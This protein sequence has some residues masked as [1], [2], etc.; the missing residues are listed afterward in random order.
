MAHI[1]EIGK[2][3]TAVVIYDKSFNYVDYKFSYYGTTHYIHQFHDADGNVLVWKTTNVVEYLDVDHYE[4][5]PE[6]S[7][8]EMTF[9]VKEHG[10]YKE[11]DQTVVTRCKF[12]LVTRAKTAAEIKMEKAAEQLASIGEN[13]FVWEMPYSQYKKHYSDCETIINSYDPH[14]DSHGVPHGHPTIKVIIRE[15]R[16]KKSGVRGEHYK[17]YRFSDG[18]HCSTAYRA[19]SEENAY[20]RFVKDH[21]DCAHWECDRVYDYRYMR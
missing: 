20:K 21:P 6:G 4:F 18:V 1:G 5:I 2:R 7:T 15:G 19:V 12:K 14:E 13:D 11:I 17:G 9:S 16:L 8:V 3:M 10:Q